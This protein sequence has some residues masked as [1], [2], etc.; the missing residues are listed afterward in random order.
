[1]KVLISAIACNPYLGSESHFGKMAVRCL[2]RDHELCVITTSRDRADMERAA[3]AGLVP[4]GV[5]FFYAGKFKPWH[6]NRLRARIQGWFEYVDFVRDSLRVAQELHRR[7]KFDVVHHLTYTTARVASPMWRLGIP[8]VYGPICGN[9][10]FPFQLF[11]ILSPSGA[12]FELARKMHNAFCRWSPSVRRSVRESAHIFASTKEAEELMSEFRGSA[13]NITLLSPA[14]YT[15]EQAAGF[16]RF[17]LGKKA[18]GPLRLYVAGHLS[19]NK[20]VAL[21][22]H[23]L[24]LA[25]KNG[26][27]FRYHL[28]AGGPEL[29]H[30]KRLAV[31]LGL[32]DE[33]LFGGNLTREEYQ[34]ELGET[35]IFLLPG[36]RESVGLTMMEAMLAGAVPSV[37]DNAG[38][39][40][41]VTEECGYK[42]PASTPGR[43]AEQMAEVII[44]ID[45]DRSII[46]KKGQAA[47]QRIATLYTE[48]HYGQT[49]NTVYET[50]A[51][52]RRG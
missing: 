9:E 37:G 40:L 44:A 45:R 18:D 7:E 47:S 6:P 11:P 14:F 38:P 43:M 5:R 30:L 8:F 17:A 36:Q 26:V 51:G 12:A 16:S 46:L 34:K 49:V 10:P 19:S 27:K 23:A 31:K 35:H 24:A 22:F 39:R 2:A 42:I 28:G 50:V 15:A 3:A 41:T 25:K 20:C 32:T 52:K 29:P 4:P 48:E 1:M 21:A 13:A 33:I